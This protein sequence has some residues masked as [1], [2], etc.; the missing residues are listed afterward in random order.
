M[1]HCMFKPSLILCLLCCR[2]AIAT[3]NAAVMTPLRSRPL[4][5]ACQGDIQK[6]C[7]DISQEQGRIAA[8]L[9]SQKRKLSASCSTAWTSAQKRW[10]KAINEDHG[11][12]ASDVE[13]FCTETEDIGRCLSANVTDLS[14]ACRNFR[15]KLKETG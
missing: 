9:N 4:E 2:A 13:K 11:A 5:D 15:N 6:Y 1:T 8:C 12:C 14:P 3:D 7:G 10:Q